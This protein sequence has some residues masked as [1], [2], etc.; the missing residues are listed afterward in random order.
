MARIAFP[1]CKTI[2]FDDK[3]FKK[4]MAVRRRCFCDEQNEKPSFI[5][6]EKDAQGIHVGYYLG[7]D[8]VGC[9]SAYNLGNGFFELSFVAVDKAY[10][11]FKVGSE[12]IDELRR[13]SKEQGAAQLV[14]EATVENIDFLKANGFPYE[15][16]SFLKNGKRYINF[17]Q[18]LVFD[19]A[20]W[21]TFND[22]KH[23]VIAK[24]EFYLEKKEKT[25]L[26]VSG[27]GFCYV[28]INGKCISD[29]VLAPAW[30]NY[31]S[32]DT[33]SMNYPIYDRMTNRILYEKIDVTKFLKKGKNTI[34]FHIGGGWFCQDEC[35]NEGVKPYGTLKLI[36]KL[37][38]GENV[39]SKSDSTL[40]Y[41]PSFVTKANI[42]YGEIHD[43]R[44]G[45][46]D[47]SEYNCDTNCWKYA[48]AT[49]MSSS[50]L[51]EQTCTPDKVIRTIK[52]KRI[53]HRGDY[54]IYDLGENIA[55]YPVINFI[56]KSRANEVCHL[57]YAENLY[58]DGAPSFESAGWENRIQADTFFHDGNVK[59]I[60]PLFTW[61]ACRYIEIIGAEV[62][63]Y[64]VC[65]TDIKPVVKFKS[66]EPTIQWI[67]DAFIRTQ[68]SNTHGCVPSDCPHRE[69]LGYTG[70]GQ[71]TADTVML[72][73]DAEKMYRKWIQ[74]IADCQDIFTGHVQHTAPFYGGGGG[75]GGWGGAMVFVP[76][77]FYKA[78]GDKELVKKYYKNMLFYLDYM[79][80]HSENGLVVREERLG[81]CLGDWCS[82]DNK[83]LIP[84]PF[85]N[86]YFYI[87]A[88][89]EV[90]E[91]SKAIGE[92]TKELEARL[93]KVEKAFLNKYYD[94]KTCTF[95]K[96]VESADAYGFD[97]GYGNEKT[98]KAIVDKYEKLGE[99]DTGIFGTK[100][101]IKT[102]CENGH[103]DLA[104]KLLSSK[105]ENTFYNMKKHGATTLW[106]NWNGEASHSHPM[107][108]AVVEYIVK[109][110]NEAK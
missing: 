86:T 88:I 45:G 79:Q 12:I 2:S 44:L 69:R 14:C 108:G 42:Y 99:F 80:D 98:L 46:Y 26:F 3:E 60:H 78:Y 7:D 62:K 89:K 43:Y 8:V 33:A 85:V 54:S 55:G 95:A 34:V 11:R 94:K 104:F 63:E 74:D 107:F 40:K 56:G 82:P 106:E 101:L 91:L 23:A 68:Q 84:I 28:Y 75:P 31:K 29:R 93:K 22:E 1:R 32:H 87:R 73:F 19:G 38:Q 110:F 30:T 58:E 64:K 70:D 109:Y 81:W 5:K 53:I 9:G 50:L 41:R 52:P 103:K 102:L 20:E 10:R 35:P 37:C 27:L 18:N 25:E 65:H 71:L 100:L 61:H 21:L 105:K 49:E 57:R 15:N 16:V 48:Q 6:N 47:F 90:I 97:L 59:D 24:Q 72:C 96:S 77:S 4:L 36:Y 92:P 51:D 83:N 67:Y 17:R 13:L 76:Y 66:S 39:V